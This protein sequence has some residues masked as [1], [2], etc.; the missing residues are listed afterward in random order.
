MKKPWVFIRVLYMNHMNDQGF[1]SMG[2]SNLETK[3]MQLAA[4]T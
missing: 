4:P 2:V 1:L 3:S